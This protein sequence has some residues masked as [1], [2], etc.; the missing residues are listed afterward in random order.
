MDL[1][2]ANL[3]GLAIQQEIV[4]AHHEGLVR[5]QGICRKEHTREKEN[6]GEMMH[7]LYHTN[8]RRSCSRLQRARLPPLAASPIEGPR[9]AKPRAENISIGQLHPNYKKRAAQEAC[10]RSQR[11]LRDD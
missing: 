6:P 8:P 2:T 4:A 1:P 11:K 9:S 5:C 3:Q 7:S 10:P